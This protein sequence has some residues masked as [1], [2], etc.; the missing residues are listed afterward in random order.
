MN[1]EAVLLPL[2]NGISYAWGVD[3]STSLKSFTSQ[4]YREQQGVGTSPG[5]SCITH[6]KTGSRE[7]RDSIEQIDLQVSL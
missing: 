5:V 3:Q 4:D 7:R 2:P 1:A 6:A